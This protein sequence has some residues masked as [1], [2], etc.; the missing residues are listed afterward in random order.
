MQAVRCANSLCSRA[1]E[2]FLS[3]WL[4]DQSPPESLASALWSIN[5]T[6]LALLSVH[7]TTTPPHHHITPHHKTKP[8]PRDALLDDLN[9]PAVV[10]ALSGPLKSIN[11]LLSTKAGRK[12]PARLPLLAQHASGVGAAAALVGMAPAEVAGALEELKGLALV[13]AGL[14]AEQVCAGVGVLCGGLGGGSTVG[15]S[16]LGLGWRCGLGFRG[17]GALLCGVVWHPTVCRSRVDL[18]PMSLPRAAAAAPTHTR[19]RS[20]SR[21]APPRAPPRTLPR[22]TPCAWGCRRWG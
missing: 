13:R 21:R 17:V 5:H 18:T 22:R 20:A 19:S 4:A 3:A 6:A 8:N 11:D 16:G 7:H 1:L 15:C 10:G 12:N 14:T 9:T 2:P